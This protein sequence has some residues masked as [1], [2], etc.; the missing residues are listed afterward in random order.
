MRY[1]Y[2]IGIYILVGIGMVL[3]A[4]PFI[5]VISTA[6]KLPHEVFAYPPRLIPTNISLLENISTVFRWIPF[7]RFFLNSVIYA[8]TVTLSTLFLS[9]LAGFGFAKYRF[10]GRDIIFMLILGTMMVP[11]QVTMIPV[12]LQLMWLGWLDTYQGLIVPGLVSAFGIFLMRQF[13]KTIPN[14]Y[15]D[16][17]RIDG[18]SDFKIYWIL[19]L[20]LSK[21]ALNA[22]GIFTFMA[23]WT[24][25]L[26]PLIVISSESKK[27]LPLGLVYF[28][29][30][31][32]T[33]WNLLMTGVLLATIPVII[34]FLIFRRYF[35]RG[36]TLTGIK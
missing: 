1:W 17:A 34:V 26:W 27:T 32:G 7:G 21:S 35:I 36:I 6:S 4:A 22:L 20:P 23:T 8:G 29:Y 15:I 24:N 9:S 12:F 10:P 11:A 19:I 33:Y 2:R 5:W 16:A 31:Y 25:F 14:E 3:M 18:A 30:Q 13:I 28:T